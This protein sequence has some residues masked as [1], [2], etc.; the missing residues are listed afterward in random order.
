MPETTDR[1]RAPRIPCTLSVEYKLRGGP[2]HK[3]RMA[4]IGTRGMLLMLLGTA[5]PVGA[6]LLFRFRLPDSARA[7][8]AVGSVRWA[9][10][11]RVGVEFV[12]LAN[13]QKN[14]IR[15]YCARAMARQRERE[16][17]DRITPGETDLPPDPQ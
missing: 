17:P 15:T 12:R 11:D 13:Q 6:D 10:V 14:E 8:Q 1:R 5:P 2:L 7:V 4:N 3:G 9:S 16:T